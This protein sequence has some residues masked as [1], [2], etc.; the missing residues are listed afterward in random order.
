VDGRDVR[1]SEPVP[2]T[3]VGE[4]LPRTAGQCDIATIDPG[5]GKRRERLPLDDG[6]PQTEL[7]QRQSRAEPRWPGPDNNHIMIKHR[8][9]HSHES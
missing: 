1:R 9:H 6:S 8:I 4:Q 5:V 3:E 2:Y 7:S